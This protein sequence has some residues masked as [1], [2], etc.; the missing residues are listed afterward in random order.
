MHL[1]TSNVFPVNFRVVLVVAF[2]LFFSFNS[3]SLLLSF[4]LSFFCGD[5][6]LFFSFW[7]EIVSESTLIETSFARQSISSLPSRPRTLTA[8]WVLKKAAVFG[9]HSV[10][11]HRRWGRP[12]QG[13]LGALEKKNLSLRDV[14]KPKV[15]YTG[16]PANLHRANARRE[17]NGMFFDEPW[18]LGHCFQSSCLLPPSF[19]IHGK[20]SLWLA[21]DRF[22][23]TCRSRK[24][25]A[26]RVGDHRP[27][28]S[29]KELAV[30]FSLLFVQ[31]GATQFLCDLEMSNSG[32]TRKKGSLPATIEV[33]TER[34]LSVEGTD[35]IHFTACTMHSMF[36]ALFGVP[37][38]FARELLMN[39][40]HL[41]KNANVPKIPKLN[42]HRNKSGLQY[43]QA[44][45]LC[46]PPHCATLIS[47]PTTRLRMFHP[48]AL[49]S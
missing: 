37:H 30:H 12:R 38:L 3:F 48:H 41:G 1:L 49:L 35:Y 6:E 26:G 13:L 20:V 44:M 47:S 9:A 14:S 11:G 45:T 46:L 21:V 33:W 25:V 10:Q 15:S 27:F 17:S 34:K 16:Q 5:L 24:D 40:P 8:P 39:S 18:G 36:R 19:V 32:S 31:P 43:A 28:Q 7:V 4:F 22:G 42:R 2:F 23:G 29:P